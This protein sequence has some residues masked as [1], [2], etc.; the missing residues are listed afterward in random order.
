[1]HGAL[2]IGGLNFDGIFSNHMTLFSEPSA[3][4]P[5]QAYPNPA[6]ESNLLSI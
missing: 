6:Y 1:L 2:D 5:S 3:F 4:D